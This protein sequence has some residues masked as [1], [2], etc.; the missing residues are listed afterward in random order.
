MNTARQASAMSDTRKVVSLDQYRP[1]YTAEQL[2]T[3]AMRF[4]EGEGSSLEE[5]VLLL[6]ETFTLILDH[7]LSEFDYRNNK[8]SMTA[9]ACRLLAASVNHYEEKLSEVMQ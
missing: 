8:R 7:I 3:E 2:I 9:I 6:P 1:L 4:K 5:S